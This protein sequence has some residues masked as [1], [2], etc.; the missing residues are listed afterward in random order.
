MSHLYNLHFLVTT[1]RKKKETGK[2]ILII[3]FI[4]GEWKQIEMSDFPRIYELIKFTFEK[5]DSHAHIISDILRIWPISESITNKY[6][7]P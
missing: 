3:Y 2:L 6:Y 7:F 5:V 1:L 4:S